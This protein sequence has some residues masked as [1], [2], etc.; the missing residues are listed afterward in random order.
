MRAFF[1]ALGLVALAASAVAAD[2]PR[3][4]PPTA[5]V[6]TVQPIS[7]TGFYVGVHA[8]SSWGR[9]GGDLTYVREVGQSRSSTRPIEQSTP[10][11]GSRGG[12]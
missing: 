3:K 4:A 9:W 1:A 10:M 12:R 11:A 7:W 8:G 2:L 5:P 6:Q